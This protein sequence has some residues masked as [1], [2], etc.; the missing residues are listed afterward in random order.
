MSPPDRHR[1][2]LY[3]GLM[4]GTSLDA[5][6][7]ALV[8]WSPEGPDTLA[9]TS[10][11]FDP[12]LRAELLALQAPGPD[13]LHRAALAAVGLSRAYAGVCAELMRHLPQ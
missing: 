5:I 3:L 9:F 8:R 4:S 10:Q 11:A 6:D 2:P 12:A 7:G 13:E 1:G